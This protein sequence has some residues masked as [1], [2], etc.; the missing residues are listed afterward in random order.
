MAMLGSAPLSPHFPDYAEVPEST[1]HFELRSLLYEFLTLAFGE[2][3]TIGC[4]QFVYWDPSN[5]RVCLSPDAFVRFGPK[6]E[7]F[8]SWKVWERGVPEV[9]V[10]IISESEGELSWDEKLDRYRQLG[11]S[12]LVRFDPESPEQ[13]LRTWDSLGGVLV[14]RRL[15]EPSSRSRHLGGYWLPVKEPNGELTLRLSRD[16]HGLS[17]FPTLAEHNA[18]LLRLEAQARQAEARAR[19][20]EAQA[21]QLA[22]HSLRLETEARRAAERRIGELE[23][24]LKR[25]S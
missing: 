18:Q 1:R 20:A 6:D 14:E 19:Q 24:E 9:A 4:D 8:R 12:E 3:A 16:Q 22:E 5:P 25:R 17:L 11:I 13:A 23:A 15:A 2:V 10:E 21:R 7:H